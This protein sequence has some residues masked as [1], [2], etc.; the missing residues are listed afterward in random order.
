MEENFN[1]KTFLEERIKARGISPKKLSELSGIPIRNLENLLNGNFKDLPAAPYI[2]GYIQK[3]GAILDFDAE[4]WWKVV[5]DSARG[6]GAFDELPKNR[7]APQ[8]AAKYIWLIIAGLGLL[9]YLALR[10]PSII[11]RPDLV[12][13]SPAAETIRTSES[14]FV[15]KGTLRGGNELSINGERI[16]VAAGGFWEK[17]LLLEPGI[18]TFVIRAAKFLGSDAQATVTIIFEPPPPPQENP[19]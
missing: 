19:S 18:N 15:I 12:I 13:S 9:I 5:R 11:G 8:S 17:N 6:S 14:S 1:F 3:L 4:G 16:N 7:F 10:L 2:R